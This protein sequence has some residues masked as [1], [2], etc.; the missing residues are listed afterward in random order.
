MNLDDLIGGLSASQ[1]APREVLSQLGTTRMNAYV[2]PVAEMQPKGEVDVD[3]LFGTSQGYVKYKKEKPEHRRMLWFRLEG[4]NVK[5][6]AQLTGYTPQSV[7]QICKQPWFVEAFCQLSA[8]RGKDAVNTFLEGEVLPALTRTLALAQSADSD[9][10]KLAA[11][12]EILDRF[13]G[14]SIAKVEAKTSSTL[15]VNVYDAAKLQEEYNRNEQI[16]RGRGIGAN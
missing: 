4:Y 6:T 12:R 10:V 2:A 3:S 1:S 8:E 14:K 13:L 16:L 5:E 9:A 11:N 15:D 7:S